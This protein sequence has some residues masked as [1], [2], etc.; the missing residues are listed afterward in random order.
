MSDVKQLVDHDPMDYDQQLFFDALNEALETWKQNEL[1]QRKLENSDFEGEVESWEDVRKLPTIDMREFKTHPEDLPVIETDPEKAFY[2]SGTTSDSKSFAARSEKGIEW[3]KDKISRYG[4][5]LIEDVDYSAV[6]ALPEEELEKLPTDMSRRG[7]F[8][9]ILWLKSDK[10]DYY[11]EIEDQEMVP[12]FEKLMDD[13]KDQE[14]R[15]IL[16]GATTLAHDFCRFLDE[17]DETVDLGEEGVVLVAGGW[18]GEQHM[19]KAELRQDFSKYLGIKPENAMD[20][21]AAT[22]F[23]FFTGSK[24]GDE[25]PDL[26][27]VPSQ[28][29]AY[30]ADE[31]KFHEEGVVEPVEEGEKGF[32]VVVDPTNPDYPGVILTDDVMRKHGEEYGPETRLEYVGRSGE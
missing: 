8:R 30:V 4:D 23:S 31:D 26:K 25:D 17:R 14:G 24:P 3:E 32:L 21:Y 28:A 7:I 2:S 11:L 9:K 12:D 16:M 5:E 6:L 18:K 22:E 13:I 29:Y 10:S 27:R 1:Y 15:G 20:V 19:T